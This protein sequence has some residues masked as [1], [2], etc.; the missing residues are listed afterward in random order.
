MLLLKL[1]KGSTKSSG[2]LNFTS[3]RTELPACPLDGDDNGGVDDVDD[4]DIDDEDC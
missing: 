4:D 2:Y 1:F 3:L